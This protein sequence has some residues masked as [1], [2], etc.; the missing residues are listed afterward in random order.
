MK[1]QILYSSDWLDKIVKGQIYETF[2]EAAESVCR[3]I[4]LRQNNPKVADQIFC[5]SLVFP[6]IPE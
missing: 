6:D 2:E 1:Y 4:M 5:V 3:S